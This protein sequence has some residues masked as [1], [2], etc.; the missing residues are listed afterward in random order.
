MRH[1]LL[2]ALAVALGS[3]TVVE[4]VDLTPYL[5]NSGIQFTKGEPPADS[6]PIGLIAIEDNGW[7]LLGFVPIIPIHLEACTKRFIESAQRMRADGISNI[8]IDY[9][10]AHP[11][12]LFA[13]G[14]PNW[15]A[16]ITMTGMAYQT[17][18]RERAR[19]LR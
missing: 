14:I 9:R 7:Y 4:D 19:P 10:P 12:R 18:D 11:L 13:I 2:L 6:Q 3:C 15:S 16:S 17:P 5:E 8:T 1:L